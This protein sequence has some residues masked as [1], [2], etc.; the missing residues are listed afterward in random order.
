MKL[1]RLRV[2]TT[3]SNHGIVSDPSGQLKTFH[4]KRDLPR[5][6]PGDLIDIDAADR[7]SRVHPR[8]TE[9]GRGDHKGQFKATAANIERLLIVIAPQPKPSPDLLTR[10]LVMAELQG[11]KATIVLNKADLEI[12]ACPPFS[13]LDALDAIGYSVVH[14]STKQ[15]TTLDRLTSF[16]AGSISVL[17]GQSGVGKSSILNAL[18]PDLGILTGALSK[19]TGK[20]KHTTTTT[21]LF[22]MPQ[23][24][25]L[26]D[27]PGVWEYGLWAVDVD[28]LAHAFVDFRPFLGHCHFRNCT[29][30]HEP[31]CAIV[32]AVAQGK[33]AAFRLEAWRRLLREQQRLALPGQ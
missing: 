8:Q 15:P 27:S 3:H 7:V 20:G 14:T 30:N 33:V 24:G 9:F 13:D 12:P 21:Q 25:Y 19:A 28:V 32:E 18:I 29:H 6:L 16:I 22:P 1:E 10:Y 2:L 11:L 31:G 17:A 4:F 23:G 5:P 26:V